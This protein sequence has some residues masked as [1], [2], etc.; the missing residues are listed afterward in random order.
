M[1]RLGQHQ[2]LIVSLGLEIQGEGVYFAVVV[3]V[4]LFL[5]WILLNKIFLKMCMYVC[6]HICRCPVRS[7]E[8]IGCH[9]SGGVTGL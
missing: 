9:L 2:K 6:A 7:E 4:S 1:G 5:L 8:D 3:F